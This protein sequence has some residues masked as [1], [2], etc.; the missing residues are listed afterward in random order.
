MLNIVLFGAP[1]AGKG[2]QAAMI[3]DKFSLIHLSTGDILR[4]E[5]SAGSELGKLAQRYTD[6]GEFVPDDVVI[7]II[8]SQIEKNPL[9][10]GFIFDGFPR[11]IA[12]AEA[13]DRM[14]DNCALK[15]STVLALEVETEQLIERLR[16]RGKSSGRA[17]DLSLDVIRNRIDVYN[18][19]TKPLID[20][21]NAQN[22]YHPINGTGDIAEI[23]QRLNI[24]IN[25][26]LYFV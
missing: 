26:D 24:H 16:I 23:F 14:M 11:T 18:S 12:Q 8:R 17:D 2:T 10:K 20:Y 1:G 15:I 25:T 21:Y 5:I 13:L 6:R 19:K 22:K 7:N 9:S 3:A 4:K